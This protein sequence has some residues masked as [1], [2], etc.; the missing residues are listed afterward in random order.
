V[1]AITRK[2]DSRPDRE[3]WFMEF[4]VPGPLRVADGDRVAALT[5]PQLHD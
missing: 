4:G 3:V 5:Q 1:D 2:H